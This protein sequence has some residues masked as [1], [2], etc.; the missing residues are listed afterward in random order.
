MSKDGLNR[1]Q[2]L[3]LAAV[4]G[5]AVFLTACGAG[6][7]SAPTP[8]PRPPTATPLPPTP[9]PATGASQI[10][11]KVLVADVLDYALT[12][13]EWPGAFGFVTF[14]LHEAL[15]N[16]EPIYFIRTDAS[17]PTFAVSPRKTGE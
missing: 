10:E 15:H 12:S 11:E 13:D 5:G 6:V 3:R 14:K 4:G 17:D 9:E 16:G 2:F 1:R 7:A 8:T